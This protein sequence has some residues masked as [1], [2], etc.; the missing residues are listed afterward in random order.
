M[1]ILKIAECV[2]DHCEEC[3]S[4]LYQVINA[5]TKLVEYLTCINCNEEEVGAKQ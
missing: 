3:G 1:G 2:G 4:H 5:D